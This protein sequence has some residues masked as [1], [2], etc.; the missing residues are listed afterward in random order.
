MYKLDIKEEA[1]RIFKKLS[2]KNRKQ[3]EIIY[4]KLNEIR[5]NPYHEY[6]FL[7]NPLNTFN[8]VHIDSSFVLIFRINHEEQLVEVCYFDHHDKVYKWRPQQSVL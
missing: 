1:D 7:T 3:L 8:R 6:K 4:K 2:K 5:E